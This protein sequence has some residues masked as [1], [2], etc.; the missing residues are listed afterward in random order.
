MGDYVDTEACAPEAEGVPDL[1]PVRRLVRPGQWGV[2]APRST[3]DFKVNGQK[4]K[5]LAKDWTRELTTPNLLSGSGSPQLLRWITEHTEIV[6][7][8]PYRD[9]QCTMTI[10]NTSAL[11]MALRML[12]RTGDY[13]LSDNYT[14]ATAVETALPMGVKFTGVDMDGEGLLPKSLR[15]VL[16]DWD[17]E[18]H[19]GARKP[20][21]LYLIHTGQNP[22]GETR[23]LQRRKDIYQVAQEHDL[24]ILEDDPYYFL[25]MDAYIPRTAGD[26]SASETPH[27][28]EDLLKL[29]VPS[30][31]SI[32]IDG[33]IMR[34]DSF[35]KVVSPGSRIGWVTAP[36]AIIERYKNHADVSTQGPSGFSQLAFFKLLDEFWGHIVTWE[37]AQAGMFQW[38][39]VDWE[40]HPDALTKPLHKIEEQIWEEAIKQGAL[41]ARGSWFNANGDNPNKG[42]FYRTTFAAAP[43]GKIEEAVKRF[44]YALRVSFQT[45]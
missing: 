28:P 8:P 11:D 37:P 24:I 10:G 32:D 38:L 40:K 13:V 23:S 34:M 16:D 4:Q 22:T 39:R 41:V 5:P 3:E 1:N 45:V 6:H 44:G 7:D 27:L 33:R 14:F 42:I 29:I 25:Q 2:S 15:D 26:V 9:W 43:L 17:P 31:L 19:G 12:T 20:G 21:L 30:Y 36:Q 35:S 18:K